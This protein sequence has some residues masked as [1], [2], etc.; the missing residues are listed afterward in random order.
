[1]FISGAR[2]ARP[3]VWL[4]EGALHHLKVLCPQQLKVKTFTQQICAQQ[5]LSS[6]PFKLF[7]QGS[8]SHTG[9]LLDASPLTRQ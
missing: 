1:M 3:L 5:Q 2:R 8:R 6:F 4:P 7:L 9:T